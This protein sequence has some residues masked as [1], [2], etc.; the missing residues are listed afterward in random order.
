MRH[1]EEPISTLVT[2]ATML[3]RATSTAARRMP[4]SRHYSTQVGERQTTQY[5]PMHGLG[6]DRKNNLLIHQQENSSL[7]SATP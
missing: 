2:P 7:W 3:R 6:M 4:L 1:I 5:K